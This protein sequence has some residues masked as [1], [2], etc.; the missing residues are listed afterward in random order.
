LR[1]VLAHLVSRAV[2]H[3]K[4]IGD[5]LRTADALQLFTIYAAAGESEYEAGIVS[6]VTHRRKYCVDVM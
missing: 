6:E 3:K 4:R 2:R 5:S 1:E